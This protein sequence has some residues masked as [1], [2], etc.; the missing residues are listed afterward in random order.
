MGV[1]TSLANLVITSTGKTNSATAG[2]D[3]AGILALCELKC[4]EASNLLTY[5][6]NDVLTD[7]ADSSN[8]ST[9]NTQITNLA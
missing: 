5:L 9:I 2:A 3:I 7:S 6:V 8:V 1:K 4:Q